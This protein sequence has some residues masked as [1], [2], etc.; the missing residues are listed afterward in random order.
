MTVEKFLKIQAGIENVRAKPEYKAN[1]RELIE[2]FWE[3]IEAHRALLIK[4]DALE[5]RTRG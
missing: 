4:L 1:P 3:L 2:D 5:G